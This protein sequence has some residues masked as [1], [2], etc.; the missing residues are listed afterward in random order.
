ME[1]SLLVHKADDLELRLKK[2]EEY[3]AL[4]KQ[5]SAPAAAPEK[6][7][8]EGGAAKAEVSPDAALLADGNEKFARK[9]YA[10]A[11]E[12]FS[13]LLKSYP[14]SELAGEAQ[15]QLAESFFIEKWYEK[16]ILEYQQVIAKYTK[17][18][19]RPAALYKQAISFEKIGDV[20]NAKAR[21][22]SLVN[23]Y[24]AAPEA[25]LARKKLQ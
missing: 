24:P 8:G 20:Q 21:F 25:K 16:A 6:K 5:E 17:S 14:K 15:F 23:L 22:K 3:L 13:A 11:R 10:G 19:R 9:S 12:S 2:I 4:D 18:L 7:A 1:D